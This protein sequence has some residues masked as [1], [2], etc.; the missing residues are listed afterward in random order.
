MLSGTELDDT[1]PVTPGRVPIPTTPH[2]ISFRQSKSGRGGAVQ[3]VPPRSPT[4]S[5]ANRM[6]PDLS[7]DHNDVGHVPGPLVNQPVYHDQQS[8]AL[9]P[10]SASHYPLQRGTIPRSGLV[11]PDRRDSRIASMIMLLILLATLLLLGFSIYLV[12]HH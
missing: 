9:A 5:P 10:G 7:S 3:N 11:V 8:F 12:V 4:S 1:V 6:G 2:Q